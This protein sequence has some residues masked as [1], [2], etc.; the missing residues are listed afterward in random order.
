MIQVK[1]NIN[2][3]HSIRNNLKSSKFLTSG[4]K[5]SKRLIKQYCREKKKKMHVTMTNGAFNE[6][7]QLFIYKG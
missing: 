4:R 6:G 2:N 1:S 3:F 5:N 7:K